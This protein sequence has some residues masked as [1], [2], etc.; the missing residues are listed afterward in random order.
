MSKVLLQI[1]W[2]QTNPLLAHVVVGETKSFE[3][4][5]EKSR[6]RS[7]KVE[8]QILNL[9]FSQVTSPSWSDLFA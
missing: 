8:G 4:L 5:K 1:S 9:D 7:R 6:V 3:K 2:L